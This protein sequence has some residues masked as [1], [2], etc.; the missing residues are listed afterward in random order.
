MAETPR[1]DRIPSG[2]ERESIS[3][4]E[5]EWVL[6]LIIEIDA[7]DFEASVMKTFRG[8]TRSAKEIES[9]KLFLHR[10]ASCPH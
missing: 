7:C 8:T 6:V 3:L 1:S 4:N 9:E 2:R 10:T 5:F